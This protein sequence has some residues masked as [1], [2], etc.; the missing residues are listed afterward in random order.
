MIVGLPTQQPESLAGFLVVFYLA[1][2]IFQAILKRDNLI[3]RCTRK[4]D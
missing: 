3:F 2:F 4:A 1:S